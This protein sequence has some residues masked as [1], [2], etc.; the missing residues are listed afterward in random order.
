MV[1]E[2]TINKFDAFFA[3]NDRR[4][5][6]IVWRADIDPKTKQSEMDI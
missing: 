3:F 6:E 2:E 5:Q 4:E 1:Y